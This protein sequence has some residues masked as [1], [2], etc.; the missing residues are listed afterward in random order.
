MRDEIV[1]ETELKERLGIESWRNL[2]K[3]KF[4]D[5]VS[6]LPNMS[7][8]VAMKV[9]EQFPNF[10]ELALGTFDQVQQQATEAVKANWKSQKKVHKAFEQYRGILSKELDRENLSPEDRFTVLRLLK[11]AIDTEAL[12]DS[13]HK[14][15]V[16]RALGMVAA[17]AAIVVAAGLTALGG[18][19]RIGGGGA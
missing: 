9:V 6:E 5:F 12:K 15:F 8:E 2:S 18:K 13:E 1:S 16:L 4:I 19:A 17:A 10:K 7:K 14:A 11:E 3:D